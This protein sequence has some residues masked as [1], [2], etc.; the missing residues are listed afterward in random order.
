M[1]MRKTAQ[2]KAEISNVEAEAEVDPRVEAHVDQV[3]VPLQVLDLLHHLME[4]TIKEEDLHHR[5]GK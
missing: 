5:K 3:L 1:S 4:I 2:S